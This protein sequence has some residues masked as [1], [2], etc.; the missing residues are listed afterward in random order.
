MKKVLLILALIGVSFAGDITANGMNQGD[1]YK[2]LDNLTYSRMY[3][4]LGKAGLTYSPAA[5]ANF[6]TANAISY[7][8]NGVIYSLAATANLLAKTT[9]SASAVKRTYATYPTSYY[10]VNVN[11]SGAY[12]I[13]SSFGDYLPPKV[14]GYTPIGAV[15][16][17]L[18][19]A[20]TAGFTLGTTL[21]NAASQNVT[22]YDIS[23]INS[24]SS[25]VS[26]TGL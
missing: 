1:L 22:F 18:T 12:Y 4:P 11:S 24:G 25:K 10:V 9:S 23:A 20:N 7:V 17:A 13:S 21:F 6:K 5:T 3:Q 2:L 15:K 26:L 8:N 19:S 14:A 16:V